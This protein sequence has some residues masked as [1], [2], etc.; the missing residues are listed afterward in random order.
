MTTIVSPS[1]GSQQRASLIADVEKWTKRADLESMVDD[2]IQLFENKAAR[3][4]RV[5]ASEAAFSGTTTTDNK[6]ILP[7]DFNGIKSLWHTT[8]PEC[9]LKSAPLAVVLSLDTGTV[10][11][12]YA[13]DGDSIR[14]NGSGDIAGVYYAGL[15]SLVDYYTNWLSVNH[16]DAYLFGVL[17]EAFLYIMD[18]TRAQMYSA[19]ADAVLSE[20]VRVDQKLNY[21]P[22]VQIRVHGTIA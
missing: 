8:Y 13:V 21:G 12:M 22:P 17:T 16:Y 7:T 10:P 2:F 5:R 3:K 18:D 19:R 4:L 14:F 15:P 11:T 9:A 6:I 1:I 20:I